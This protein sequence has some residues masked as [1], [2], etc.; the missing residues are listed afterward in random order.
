MSRQLTRC[1][2]CDGIVTVT[3]LSC[4]QCDTSIRSRFDSC[5]FC[6]L[7]PEHLSF[8]EL[9]LRCE[10]NLSR[11]EKELNLSYPTV[12]NRFSAALAALGLIDGVTE[13]VTPPV[14]PPVVNSVEIAD[15]RRALLDGL[16]RGEITAE[17]VAEQF[18]ALSANGG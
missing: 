7:A 17:E 15:R 6:R 16:A 5:R 2:V 14:E 3:E 12:R 4:T 9:F 11:V 13:T 18:R 1:P 10:G 8:I